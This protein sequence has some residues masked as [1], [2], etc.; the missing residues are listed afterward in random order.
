MSL[1]IFS[2]FTYNL[3]DVTQYNSKRDFYA[4]G[5]KDLY[6]GKIRQECRE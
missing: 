4:L 6:T 3:I 2:E 5:K 1:S